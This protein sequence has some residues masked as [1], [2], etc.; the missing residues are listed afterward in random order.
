MTTPNTVSR[1]DIFDLVTLR[2]TYTSTDGVTP[3]DPSTV[4]FLVKN[5]LGTVATY[6]FAAAGAS[7]IRA[8]AGAYTKQVVGDV[9]GSWFYRVHGTGGVHANEEYSFIVDRSF[10]L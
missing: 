1:Y 9:V 3:A 8:G 6:N 7:V 10:V 4:M 2:A 5:P